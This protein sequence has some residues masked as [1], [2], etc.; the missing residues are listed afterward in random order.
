MKK[1]KIQIGLDELNESYQTIINDLDYV[2]NKFDEIFEE[3]EVWILGECP[4]CGKS[5]LQLKRN[6]YG[7]IEEILKPECSN[8]HN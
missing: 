6:R 7:V 1:D 4:M 2:K 3:K 5:Q 8:N